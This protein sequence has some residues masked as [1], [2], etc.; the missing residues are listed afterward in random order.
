M[1]YFNG[2]GK[3]YVADRDASGNPGG[4]RFLGNVPDFKIT[5]KT[6]GEDHKES[7]S[8]NR[9]I[10]AHIQKSKEVDAHFS[11]EEFSAKNIAMAL[12]GIDSTKTGAAV[13]AESLVVTTLAVNDY[14]RTKFPNISSVVVKDNASATLTLGTHY[15]MTS[16]KHGSMQIL[17]L[18]AYVQPFKID[19]T[20]AT[21]SPVKLLSD[22]VKERYL[23]FEGLN[24]V[25]QSNVLVELYRMIVDPAENWEMINDAVASWPCNGN[26]MYDSTRFADTD[27]GGFGR[28][29][30]I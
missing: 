2:Q 18:A 13:T 29:I 27:L 26:C 12:Y 17:N 10:D 9:I 7:Q 6:E 24:V 4:F 30:Q 3:V 5:I 22:V 11:I 14:I 28:L 21:H 23:R 20:Y 19:Y 15:Q 25:D 8:G 1:A 16:A